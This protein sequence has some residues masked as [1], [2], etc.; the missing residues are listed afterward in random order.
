M[1]RETAAGCVLIV[2]LLSEISRE[3]VPPALRRLRDSPSYSTVSV[4]I[5]HTLQQQHQHSADL[6]RRNAALAAGHDAYFR[7]DQ[8]IVVMC[9]PRAEAES[10]P[11]PPFVV[12]DLSVTARSVV[13][14]VALQASSMDVP[15]TSTSLPGHP[16]A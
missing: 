8:L 13:S 9:P 7:R 12:R 6:W 5:D 10:T 2:I 1:R 3:S 15:S 16:L 4:F 14:S 11:P